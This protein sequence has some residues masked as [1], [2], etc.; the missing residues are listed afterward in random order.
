MKQKTYIAID[1]KSFYASVECVE[2][3]LDPMDTLL[4]VADK[5]R[6]EKTICLAVSPALKAWK[7]PGRA[8]L[9][10]V[11]QRVQEVNAQRR[12]QAPGGRFTGKS[13]FASAL[14]ADSGL[15]LD[16]LIAPPR[17]AYYMEY[18]TR[19]YQIYLKYVS[20]EDVH[21]YSI[22]EVFIDATDY[23]A[24]AKQTPREFAMRMILDV[25][26]ETGV[27]ATAGIGTNLY[28]CKIAMDIGAKHIEPDEN[29]VRIAE[30][31]EISYRR[32]LWDHTPITDFWRVGPGY[33]R[34]LASRGMYTMG[35]VARQSLLD[36]DVLYKLFGVNAE[37]L[38]DHAWGEESCTIGDI[39]G[40]RPQ[41]NS[42]GSGQ[43]LTCP[44]PFDK[45]LLVIR[46]M[47]DALSMTLVEKGLATR[48]LAL[49]VGYDNE[50]ISQSG[51]Y[52]GE[53]KSDRYGRQIPKPAHGVTRL[54]EKTASS[55]RIIEA[56][57]AL[58]EEIVDRRLTIRRM[59][60]TAL[61][62]TAETEESRPPEQLN[63]F[64]DYAAEERRRE[65]EAA[66]LAREKKRQRAVLEI[67]KKFGK[68]AVVRGMDLLEGATARDRNRQIGGHK[69]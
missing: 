20:A 47:A 12:R 50:N 69:A 6:T 62:V 52:R 9:F 7:I 60:L 26:K 19:I 44:Y 53:I 63:M 24:A 41:E 54:P 13:H 40:Y 61:E 45:A 39:K 48:Q 3:K 2:R 10:E 67:R 58:F 25:L 5:S 37:L 23:L 28:L 42:I 46:E 4:V 15:E 36:E 1:L 21:V 18:S 34:R 8:R 30:L 38:I 49:D 43:V 32:Q 51:S 59:N 16:Y 65:A 29:G 35:D 11:I 33:Q 27:T 64:T 68:N 57:G 66:S 14:A 56:V 22:D 55:R 31:D 17:M